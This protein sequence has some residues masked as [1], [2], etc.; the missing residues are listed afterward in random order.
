[1]APICALRYDAHMC[2]KLWRPHAQRV[3]DCASPVLAPSSPTGSH[4]ITHIAPSTHYLLHPCCPLHPLPPRPIGLL[5][6][7][8]S[9]IQQDPQ[10]QHFR[11]YASRALAKGDWC[12]VGVIA[13][14]SESPQ[15]SFESHCM[16]PLPPPP[17]LRPKNLSPRVL[18]HLHSSTTMG[19]G[20]TWR[21]SVLLRL[22]LYSAAMPAAYVEIAPRAPS[23]PPTSRCFAPTPRCDHLS[24]I[25]RLHDSCLHGC[26]HG[27]W[28]RPAA[29]RPPDACLMIARVHGYMVL[30]A[31]VHGCMMT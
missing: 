10:H 30:I 19:C 15:I 2:T 26:M 23:D 8:L 9:L 11:S 31:R 12:D 27:S 13:L 14:R 29:P 7:A 28:Q 18:Y 5:L 1:M 22:V 4:P 3:A 16:P 20:I 6:Q 25:T 24:M 17:P 21:P